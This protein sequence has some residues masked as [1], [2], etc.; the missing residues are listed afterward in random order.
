M[1]TLLLVRRGGKRLVGSLWAIAFV[2]A[3][4]LLVAY[5]LA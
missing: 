2:L 1:S 5:F 4:L 3:L